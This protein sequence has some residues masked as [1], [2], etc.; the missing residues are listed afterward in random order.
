[1][2]KT[3]IAMAV[4][5]ASGAA[6]AQSSVTLFGVLDA[7]VGRYSAD[8]LPSVTHAE[9]SGIN[10]TRLGFKGIEDLGGGMAASFWWEA[11]VNVANGA[12]SGTNTNNLSTGGT[13]GNGLTFNRRS[14]L[15]LK[16][17]FGI[18]RI[19]RDYSP[20][21]QNKTLY[22][23][24]GTNG[25]AEVSNVNLTGTGSAGVRNSSGVS[26]LYGYDTNAQS[27]APNGKGF[28]F[29]GTVALGGSVGSND[30]NYQGFRTGYT[31]GPVS[32][33]VAYAVTKTAAVS[34]Y[35][36]QNIGGSYDLGV[37][38]LMAQYGTN[39]T[40][41]NAY[42]NK[43]T[44]LGAALPMGAGL[45]NASYTHI[46]GSGAKDPGSANQLGLGYIYNLSKRTALYGQYATI[47][48]SGGARYAVTGAPGAP[49]A[50]GKSSGFEFGFR[51][52][53]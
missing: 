52:F 10:S 37:A 23:P 20:E 42:N 32:V 7:G 4:L 27:Y 1:M 38:N 17:D 50:N 25:V 46:S 28:F 26:Y 34:D 44:L 8:G 30:G 13:T 2:K 18:I 36:V 21:F 6:M 51:N 9:N 49:T 29:Q 33:G 12:G 22:D 19:G 11:G 24:F 47:S 31:A 43:T 15:D 16:G 40:G 41:N 39:K 3:L 48:N 5:A 53:F 14:T 35:K 45:I